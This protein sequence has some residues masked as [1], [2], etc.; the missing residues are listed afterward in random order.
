MTCW[1]CSVR[2]FIKSNPIFLISSSFSLIF[3]P[4]CVFCLSLSS[5]HFCTASGFY[6]CFSSSTFLLIYPVTF[7]YFFL[8][9]LLSFIK[10]PSFSLFF[11]ISLWFSWLSSY[12]LYFLYFFLNLFISFISLWFF[13]LSSITFSSSILSSL[14]KYLHFFLIFFT[15]PLCHIFCISSWISFIVFLITL[16][17]LFRFLHCLPYCIFKLQSKK[18]IGFKSGVSQF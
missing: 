4:L 3:L 2:R 18:S 8:D 6:L 5:L 17:L 7:S 13:I 9:F 11:F 12:F 10:M 15:V 1:P 16:P 14:L